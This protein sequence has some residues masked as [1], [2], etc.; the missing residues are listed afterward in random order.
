MPPA[1]ESIT[2]VG[3]MSRRLR[4]ARE[5]IARRNHV[6][7]EAL[8]VLGLYAAY[9]MSR[10]L[11]ND[12]A[13]LALDHAREVVSLEERLQ[14]FHEGTLQ[15][16]VMRLPG[17]IDAFGFAYMS[18][19]LVGT[20]AVLIWLYARRPDWFPLLRTALAIASAIALS[21]YFLYP[22]APPRL[23]GIGIVDTVTTINDIDLRS[24]LLGEFYNPFAAIPSMHFG[25]ALLLGVSVAW[26]S[27]P[28]PVRLAALAYPSFVLVV[29]VGTGN[30]FILDA[31]AGAAV[32]AVGLAAAWVVCEPGDLRVPRPHEEVSAVETRR[33]GAPRSEPACGNVP[34]LL[35]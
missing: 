21:I 4:R 29:I 30:H 33:V 2:A 20:V 15:D 11:A 35:G 14:L 13:S 1:S 18:L 24:R 22:T 23:A 8:V 17:M 12:S 6:V 28:L 7:V 9:Q 3:A 5:R 26:L 32:S 34:R 10:A 16:A 27:R 31:V 25:Y 19:H